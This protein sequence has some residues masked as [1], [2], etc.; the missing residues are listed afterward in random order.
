MIEK[1]LLKEKPINCSLFCSRILSHGAK[2][3]WTNKINALNRAIVA[4]KQ[5]ISPVLL[6]RTNV[7][8]CHHSRPICVSDVM[9]RYGM[10]DRMFVL[11]ISG[12]KT[13]DRGLAYDDNSFLDK[14]EAHR[15][16]AT[17]QKILLQAL[18]A[19]GRN[20]SL[21]SLSLENRSFAVLR[22]RET[23]AVNKRSS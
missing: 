21:E 8:I 5:V 10:Q 22:K 6:D 13:K 9:S 14:D 15:K 2:P 17:R 23:W 1:Q 11:L 7:R 20:S 4:F 16:E 12:E 3:R 18:G 19:K